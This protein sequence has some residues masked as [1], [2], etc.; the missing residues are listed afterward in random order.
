[1]SLILVSPSY[2]IEQNSS[3]ASIIGDPAGLSRTKKINKID[4]QTATRKRADD[5]D[6]SGEV[7]TRQLSLYDGQDRIGLIVDR[8][9]GHVDAFDTS[10]ILLGTFKKIKAAA[11]AV[12]LSRSVSCVPD[13]SARQDNS[14]S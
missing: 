8:G 3:S 9:G 13:T 1:L 11:N 14:G 4:C 12:S 6:L 5:K 2:S 7:A 10:G